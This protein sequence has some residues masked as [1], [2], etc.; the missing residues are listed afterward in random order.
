MSRELDAE[1]AEKVMGLPVVWGPRPY[2]TT[3][4][5]GDNT[6]YPWLKGF[7]DGCEYDWATVEKYSS[8]IAAAFQVVEKMKHAEPSIEWNAYYKSWKVVMWN[9]DC[10]ERLV[11]WADDLPQAICSAALSAVERK[12]EN[13]N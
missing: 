4:T 10:T 13:G 7:K 1:V 6:K 11:V 3:A 2:V 12:D 5:A 8:D 9:V